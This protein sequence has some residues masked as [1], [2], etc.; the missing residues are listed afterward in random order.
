MK[1]SKD[2]LPYKLYNI[3]IEIKYFSASVCSSIQK[4][5]YTQWLNII[6]ANR[7]F[8]S[9]ISGDI[10]PEGH[11]CTV[12]S[13][14]AT[15]CGNG[16]YM[17]HTGATSCYTCPAG[18]YCVNRDRADLCRQ[19]Y[20]CPE[21]TGADLQPCPTGTFGNSEG[22]IQE[23]QCTSC[24]GWSTFLVTTVNT[25][26]VNTTTQQNCNN[27]GHMCS[28]TLGG[29]WTSN[30]EGPQTN[31]IILVAGPL[32]FVHPVHL[33]AMLTVILAPLSLLKSHGL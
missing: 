17:N 11:Y 13:V 24:T 26:T 21:G 22:L 18:Y 19:G 7:T 31:C 23:S 5:Y 29:P 1:Y 28:K 12:G 3:C 15:P 16:T 20:Y 32:D 27:G 10:C 6:Q 4:C 30:S 14:T 2:V 8:I 9:N 25:M 33:L